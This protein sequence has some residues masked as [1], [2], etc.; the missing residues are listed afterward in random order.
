MVKTNQAEK[1]LL[2]KANGRPSYLTDSELY[3]NIFVFNLAGYKTNASSMTFA[4]S[5]HAA[6]HET[7]DWIPQELQENYSTPSA[8]ESYDEYIQ[9]RIPAFFKVDIQ[10]QRLAM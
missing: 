10:C 6:Y 3:C 8:I 2:Q 4:L 1:G 9:S 7:Q 5:Y